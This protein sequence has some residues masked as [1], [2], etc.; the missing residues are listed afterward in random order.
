MYV[1][2]TVAGLTESARPQKK[3]TDDRAE[4]DREA[5][6]TGNRRWVGKRGSRKEGW[7]GKGTE[8]SRFGTWQ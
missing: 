8:I 5:L 2:N 1:S 7:A 6:E 3:R 4:K